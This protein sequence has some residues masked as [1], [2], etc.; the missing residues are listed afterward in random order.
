MKQDKS[1][2]TRYAL[3]N[4]THDFN[5]SR[6]GRVAPDVIRE[7]WNEL[8][9][10]NDYGTWIEPPERYNY[11][12]T[13]RASSRFIVYEN[14]SDSW[15]FLNPS[16]DVLPPEPSW[17]AWSWGYAKVK[18]SR[19]QIETSFIGAWDDRPAVGPVSGFLGAMSAASEWF[20]EIQDVRSEQT[21]IYV[22]KDTIYACQRH[23]KNVNSNDSDRDKWI[24]DED[25]VREY[26]SPLASFEK[27]HTYRYLLDVED[28]VGTVKLTSTNGDNASHTL[29]PMSEHHYSMNPYWT[30]QE[31][32]GKGSGRLGFLNMLEVRVP[33]AGWITPQPA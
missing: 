9:W 10:V 21:G 28:N 4:H 27:G 23:V 20:D 13:N 29:P 15:T 22:D 2:R 17:I 6:E 16:D 25:P 26:L 33:L 11:G 8:I 3:E 7:Q 1:G 5:Q 12:Q 18:S 19:F 31:L 24:S 30:S 32:S 14:I